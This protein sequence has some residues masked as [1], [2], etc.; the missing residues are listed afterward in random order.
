MIYGMGGFTVHVGRGVLYLELLLQED[1][2]VGRLV[3]LL[4]LCQ[5][6]QEP[7][8]TNKKV[9]QTGTVINKTDPR[10]VPVKETVK[11]AESYSRSFFKECQH[12]Y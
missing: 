7:A 8:T 1:P 2:E 10:P 5:L 4:Q 9:L 11:D 6:H 3:R 12:V